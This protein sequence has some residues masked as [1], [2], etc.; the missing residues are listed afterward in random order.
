MTTYF[1][2]LRRHGDAVSH[3]LSRMGVM[4]L[5]TSAVTLIRDRRL[6]FA[7]QVR[8][9]LQAKAMELSGNPQI[10][11]STVTVVRDGGR[12]LEETLGVVETLLCQVD[13]L[14]AALLAAG[15]SAHRV[16]AI[17]EGES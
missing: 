12:A 10:G 7:R 5:D 11:L 6:I 9:A 13:R 4:R 1:S 15:V 14:S 2:P 17:R 16:E 8:L 3:G